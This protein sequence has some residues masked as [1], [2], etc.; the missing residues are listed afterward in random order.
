MIYF[1]AD[2][3]FGH[4]AIIELCRRPFSSV[5][6]M[7]EA[8]IAN[9]NRRVRDNDTVFILGDFAYRA[10]SSEVEMILKR[11]KGKK[12]LIVGNHDRSWLKKLSDPSVY[13][14][15]IDEYLSKYGMTLCHYPLVTYPH[16]TKQRMIHGHIHQNT[17]MDYWQVLKNR[18][19]VLNV[20]VDI[21]GFEPVTLE[22]AQENNRL[23]KEAH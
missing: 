1:T 11:L 17:D 16:E 23:W 2:T 20:G 4:R 19:L 12:R 15:S 22:E 8:L 3:H 7:N 5:E 6:E 9:W 10:D 14:D 13:F 18:P 21:N